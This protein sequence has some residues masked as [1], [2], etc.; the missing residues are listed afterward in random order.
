MSKHKTDASF[1]LG[2]S[3]RPEWAKYKAIDLDGSAY[4]YENKPILTCV[5]WQVDGGN[6]MPVSKIDWKDTLEEL[7]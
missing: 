3:E 5:D 6:V 2:V 4:W 1:Y 7:L